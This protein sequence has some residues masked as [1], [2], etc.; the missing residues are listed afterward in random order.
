MCTMPL[1]AVAAAAAVQVELRRY[2]QEGINW[3]SFLRRFGLNGVLAD[4]MG[5]GKTLQATTIMACSAAER[6][7]AGAAAAPAAGTTAENGAQH[8]LDQH[9]S[10]GSK[11]AAAAAAGLMPS[12]VVCPSTLVGHWA[13]EINK[14]VDESVLRPLAISGTPAE[15][16]SAQQQLR[17]GCAAA[18]GCY[19]VVIISYESLR[20]DADWA[21]GI[22]W[23]YIVLDE[24]HV[25]RST[26]SK[27]AQAVKRLQAQHRLVLSG[28]PIQN[29][30]LELWSLFD[31]LMPGFLGG[32]RQS[33]ALT[34]NF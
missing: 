11:A 6:A 23:D 33:T 4:D 16:A 18:G 17:Q 26:K 13:H 10:A 32:E 25:I 30:A 9:A 27:L 24:G 34:R 28:T 19:N 1:A 2:Q 21:S 8:Q 3:L 5:L 22:S 14:Y 31:F 12:L 15:R 20:S 7:A 29:S